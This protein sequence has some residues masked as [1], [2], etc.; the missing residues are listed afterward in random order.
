MYKTGQLPSYSWAFEKS[1]LHWNHKLNIL[2]VIVEAFLQDLIPSNRKL[3]TSFYRAFCIE[4]R[5]T[6]VEVMILAN[7]HKQSVATHQWEQEA[8]AGRRH[9]AQETCVTAWRILVLHLIGWWIGASF[10]KPMG[11]RWSKAIKPLYLLVSYSFSPRI[12]GLG[13]KFW[14]LDNSLTDP[15]PD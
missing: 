10:F 6:T 5:K 1:F 7:Q 8:K 4:C 13:D 12:M 3:Y 2:P 15:N 14:G 9:K 11:A